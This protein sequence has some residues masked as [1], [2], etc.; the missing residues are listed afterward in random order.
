MVSRMPKS[1]LQELREARNL[2]QDMLAEKAGVGQSTVHRIETGHLPTV[3]AAV[4]L[5]DFFD[6]SLDELL[7]REV[8][9]EAS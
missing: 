5:A 7:G 2:T 6:V 8:P 3:R 9:A 1:R 4:A